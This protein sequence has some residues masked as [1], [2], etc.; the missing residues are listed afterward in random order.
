MGKE[1]RSLS[2]R[3]V[4][5]RGNHVHSLEWP[6]LATTILSHAQNYNAKPKPTPSDPRKSAIGT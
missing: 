5:R 2:L 4:L 1:G 3:G 6:D